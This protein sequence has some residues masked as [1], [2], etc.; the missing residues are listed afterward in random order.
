MCGFFLCLFVGAVEHWYNTKCITCSVQGNIVEL[1]WLSHCLDSINDTHISAAHDGKLNWRWN[2][3]LQAV[4]NLHSSRDPRLVGTAPSKVY[5]GK[6]GGNRDKVP[7]RC[8]ESLY[9][10]APSALRLAEF[11]KVAILEENE[12]YQ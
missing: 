7:R 8:N 4:C 11:L 2:V 1:S 3:V 5:R 9:L 12:V 10:P 6:F